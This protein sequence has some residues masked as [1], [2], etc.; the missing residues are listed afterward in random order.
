MGNKLRR[1]DDRKANLEERLSKTGSTG[2]LLTE[3]QRAMTEK[4]VAEI[5]DFISAIETRKAAL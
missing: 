5:T 3:L 4:Q 2:L 1:L